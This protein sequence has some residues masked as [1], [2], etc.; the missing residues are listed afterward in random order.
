MTGKSGE[1]GEHGRIAVKFVDES[2][3]RIAGCERFEGT[4]LDAAR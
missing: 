2:W 4:D 1:A 3:Q